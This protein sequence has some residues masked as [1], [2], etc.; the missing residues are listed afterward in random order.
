M[1]IYNYTRWRRRRE[2]TAVPHHIHCPSYNASSCLLRLVMGPF[3]RAPP[4]RSA[5]QRA[6]RGRAVGRALYLDTSTQEKK[7][8]ERERERGNEGR[9]YRQCRSN[10]FSIDLRLPL[11]RCLATASD[12]RRAVLPKMARSLCPFLDDRRPGCHAAV[13]AANAHAY[14]IPFQ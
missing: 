11:S 6:G 2:R 4:D 1:S 5:G 8:E 12:G 9:R 14:I 10:Q 3:S 7:T 13:A